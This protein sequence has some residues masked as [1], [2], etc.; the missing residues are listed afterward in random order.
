MLQSLAM[1]AVL[2]AM[3]LIYS[4][5]VVSSQK[6][7]G[8]DLYPAGDGFLVEKRPETGRPCRVQKS[9]GIPVSTVDLVIVWYSV[10]SG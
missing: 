4:V 5:S 1:I 8:W 10:R 7:S 2:V 6:K 3:M 9:M